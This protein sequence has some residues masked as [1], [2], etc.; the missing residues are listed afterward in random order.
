MDASNSACDGCGNI[1]VTQLYQLPTGETARLCSACHILALCLYLD[2]QPKMA[3]LK[4]K[5]YYMGRRA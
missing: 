4:A 1:K 5:A 3:E 2:S